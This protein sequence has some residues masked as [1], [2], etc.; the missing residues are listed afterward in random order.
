MG[1]QGQGKKAGPPKTPV[2]MPAV[3]G[4]GQKNCCCAICNFAAE[5]KVGKISRL[6]CQHHTSSVMPK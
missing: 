5:Q 4:C 3:E 2:Q 1:L 6:L